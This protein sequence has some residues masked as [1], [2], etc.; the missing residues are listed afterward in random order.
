VIRQAPA[1]FTDTSVD[2]LESLARASQ[3][4]MQASSFVIW[5]SDDTMLHRKTVSRV[6]YER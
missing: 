6:R 3:L 5:G 4:E 1:R 2:C